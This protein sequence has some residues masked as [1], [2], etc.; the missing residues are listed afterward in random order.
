MSGLVAK[1]VLAFAIGAGAH[2]GILAHYDAGGMW[3]MADYYGLPHRNCHVASDRHPLG[4]IIHIRGENTGV[5]LDCLVTDYSAPA[6][7][8]RHLN[9]GLFEVDIGSAR[10]LCGRTDLPN[11]LCPATVSRWYYSIIR[12]RRTK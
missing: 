7:L 1:V 9:A 6:D 12:P 10:K 2:D 8:Q 11:R 4:A 5:E 3:R